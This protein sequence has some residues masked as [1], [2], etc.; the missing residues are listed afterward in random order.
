MLTAFVLTATIAGATL[1]RG[2]SRR[3]RHA[4]IVGKRSTSS[5]VRLGRWRYV[6][7]GVMFFYIL[8]SAVVPFLGLLYLSLQKFWAA[9][10]AI[11]FETVNFERVFREGSPTRR[12]IVNSAVL[13]IA[14]ATLAMGAA[15]IL[16]TF[17]YRSRS[18]TARAVDGVTKLPATISHLVLAVGILLAF[19]GPPFDLGGTKTLL[20]LGFFI[21]YFALASFT[22]NTAVGQISNELVE[23]AAVNGARQGRTFRKVQLPLMIPSLIGGWIL[24]FVSTIGDI[25]VSALLA[26]TQ[27]PVVGFRMLDLQA[28]GSFPELA[29]LGV[30]MTITT[31]TV[32]T[33]ATFLLNRR[34]LNL[35][36]QQT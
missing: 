32:V 33:A 25:T 22:A 23:A 3:N 6:A 27:T 20:M 18:V 31:I 30:V 9:D 11:H 4:A 36:S 1:Q 13:G 19:A 5:L 35:R 16:A 24:V 10:F 29:A 28:T 17:V 14:V 8:I 21:C 34:G 15:T 2:L 26:G 7:K 12:S